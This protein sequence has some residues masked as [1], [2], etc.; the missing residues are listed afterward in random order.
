MSMLKKPFEERLFQLIRSLEYQDIFMFI[1][2]F[3]A[4]YPTRRD[5]GSVCQMCIDEDCTL[6]I[7]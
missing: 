1:R 5:Y 6:K 3:A 2:D 4:S 7:R